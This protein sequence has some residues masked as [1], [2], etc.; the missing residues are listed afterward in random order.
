M[1]LNPI[2]GFL[3]AVIKNEKGAS[4]IQILC[5]LIRATITHFASFGATFREQNAILKV[6]HL[7]RC[8]R[9]NFI[10]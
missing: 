3:V 9:F 1:S 4:I 5:S 8:E 7:S 6:M 10:M 2:L